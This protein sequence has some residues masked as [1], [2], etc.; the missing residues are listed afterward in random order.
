MLRIRENDTKLELITE[1]ATLLNYMRVTNGGQHYNR[2]GEI[3]NYIN[4]FMINN[5]LVKNIRITTSHNDNQNFT[6]INALT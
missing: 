1:T 2:R 4:R 6:T 5:M 3:S